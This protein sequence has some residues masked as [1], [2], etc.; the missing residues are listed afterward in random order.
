M[1]RRTNCPI[2]RQG[3]GTEGTNINIVE[4]ES[5]LERL[6]VNAD[7]WEEYVTYLREKVIETEVILK[8]KAVE[9]KLLSD[10]T[11]NKGEVLRVKTEELNVKT[12][13]LRIKTFIIDSI[14]ANIASANY[15]NRS[16]IRRLGL[17]LN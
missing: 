4:T 16:H 17:Q 9:Y 8:A 15:R 10:K 1:K 2:C 11:H 5:R 12:E 6:I 3:F 13:E 14:N 7:E